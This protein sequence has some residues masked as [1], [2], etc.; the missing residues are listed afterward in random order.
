MFYKLTYW[1]SN[2]YYKYH[3]EIYIC[4]RCG[5]M[6]IPYK[7]FDYYSLTHDYGWKKLKNPKRWLCHHCACHENDDLTFEQWKNCADYYNLSVNKLIDNVS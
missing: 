4:H 7:S 3:K 1:L 2:L 5:L 6:E